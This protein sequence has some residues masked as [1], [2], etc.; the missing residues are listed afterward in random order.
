MLNHVSRYG[1]T[2][3]NDALRPS[4]L[5]RAAGRKVYVFEKPADGRDDPEEA[6]Q[7]AETKTKLQ[8]ALSTLWNGDVGAHAASL[9]E[10][11]KSWRKDNA[12]GGRGVFEH[13]P[14]PNEL[15]RSVARHFDEMGEGEKHAAFDSVISQLDPSV[16]THVAQQVAGLIGQVGGGHDVESAGGIDRRHSE[17]FG[18][19]AVG[20]EP[21]LRRDTQ[22]ND[23]TSG[24]ARERT[25]G[26]AVR[27]DEYNDGRVVQT[28]DDDGEARTQ[29]ETLPYGRASMQATPLSYV[30]AS[31][32]MTW[33]GSTPPH[34]PNAAADQEA[35]QRAIDNASHLADYNDG[36]IAE[37]V[38]EA[39]A[40]STWLERRTG[41]G[42][43]KV[44]D[45]G[46]YI[47]TRYGWVDLQ[48][49]IG[50]ATATPFADLNL[51][52]GLLK[53]GE[54][55]LGG[56][57]S[58]GKREDYLSN[59]IGAQALVRQRLFGGTIGQAVAYVLAQYRPLTRKQAAEFLRNGGQRED[60]P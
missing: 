37:T 51:L 3:H 40:S 54:Q 8:Q 26:N 16:R 20:G 34:R 12:T 14:L 18:A 11:I 60:W 49:V 55:W 15:A 13:L 33:G 53:E 23:Y 17:R 24:N 44:R 42:G 28:V 9:D 39:I 58:A 1:W 32:G 25:A 45:N 22:P 41:H 38:D 19:A 59:W 46:R 21:T 52:L 2:L 4:L 57:D 29:N 31:P 6:P 43:D 10:V 36:R 56:M 48:H 5:G 35:R 50:A 27:L 30:D 47:W 7:S